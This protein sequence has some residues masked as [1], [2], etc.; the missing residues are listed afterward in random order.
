MRVGLIAACMPTALR[1]ASRT[2][3]S[4]ATDLDASPSSPSAPAG[5][6]TRAQLDLEIR[7]TPQSISVV[8]AAQMRRFDAD[9]VNEAPPGHRRAWTSGR[10]TAPAGCARGFDILTPR[11]MASACPTAGAS[12]LAPST[13]SATEGR[14]DPR[15]QRPAHRRGQRRGHDQLRAQVVPPTNARLFGLSYGR[16]YVARRVRLLDAV[17]RR[18]HLVGAWSPRTRTATWL[19]AT[20]T[21][22][23]R[24][25]RG[26]W[27]GGRNGTL[28][29]AVTSAR[30]RTGSC[31]ARG[32]R[33]LT[34][35]ARVAHQ[36]HH[37]PGLDVL[38]HHHPH[39]LHRVPAPPGDDWQP[40]LP[41]TIG[42]S[43]ATSACSTPTTARARDWSPAPTWPGR[44]PGGDDRAVARLGTATLDGRRGLRPRARAGGA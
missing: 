18:R 40:S 21:A 1:R 32:V 5:S 22:A 34:L 10:P 3:R 13:P 27:P 24:L 39:R 2:P 4:S 43:A 41:T 9:S 11:S 7:D 38:E 31:G 30:A 37:H 8:D 15:R 33:T 28:A 36:R 23:T 12:P 19:R 17:H 44:L 25:R 26:R 16:G 6:A 20:T 29:L 42:A 35:S 14:G